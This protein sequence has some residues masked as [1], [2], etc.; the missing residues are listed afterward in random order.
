MFDLAVVGGGIVGL[1]TA[2]RYLQRFAGR[3]VLLLEKENRLA[4]HQSGHNSGVLHSGLYYAPGSLKATLCRRGKADMEALLEELEVPWRR[5]GKLI[6]A[7]EP[8]ELGRLTALADRARA[9]GV[10]VSEV[11]PTGIRELEPHVRGLAGLHVPG[12]GVVDFRE[13]CE[14]MAREILHRSGEIRTSCG[15]RALEPRAQHVDLHL[16][17]GEKLTAARAITCGGLQADR[18]AG[19]AGGAADVRIVPFLGEY[20]GLRPEYR[21]R[22]RGLVYPVPDPRFPFLGVHFTRRI[23][24][25]VDCGPNALPA[26]AREGYSKRS[27]NPRDTL[28][29]L[30]WPGFWRLAGR[31]LPRTLAELRRSISTAAFARGAARLVPEL[32]ANWLEPAPCGVRAQALDR[33]GRLVDD[34]LIRENGPVLHVIN[35]PSP[36]ATA[37]LAIAE[38]L[39]DRLGGQE[40]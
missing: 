15:V 28:S 16:V 33:S 40:P 4:A 20:Y 9:N 32:E 27:F 5:S 12:T 22:V 6:V 30:S 3:S 23:D 7:T 8:E 34:F 37:S 11:G 35:A 24:G 14:A 2:F 25:R 39:L 1:A 19:L 17:S 13:V 38:H 21:T 26:W 29:S 31:H 10:G 36:A 18:L